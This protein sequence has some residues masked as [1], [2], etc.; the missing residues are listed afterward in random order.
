MFVEGDGTDND[1]ARSLMIYKQ[2]NRLACDIT[3]QSEMH[4]SHRPRRLEDS[5][6]QNGIR[7]EF[8]GFRYY[9]V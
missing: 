3:F 5:G 6:V 2:A 8:R 4:K 7:L 9:A 1:E